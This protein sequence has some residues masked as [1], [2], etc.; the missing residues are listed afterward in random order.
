MSRR[1]LVKLDENLSRTHLE[2]L[3]KCGWLIVFTTKGSRGL[4]TRWF[5]TGWLPK[6]AF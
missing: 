3:S 1:L 6:G 2:F 4:A 5:G